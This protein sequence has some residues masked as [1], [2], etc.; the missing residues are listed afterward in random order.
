MP[1]VRSGGPPG[2]STRQQLTCVPELR[3]VNTI[4]LGQWLN[5][6]RAAEH[7]QWSAHPSSCAAIPSFAPFGSAVHRSFGALVA[8]VGRSLVWK[9]QEGIPHP[10]NPGKKF[11][12]GPLPS[13]GRGFGAGAAVDSAATQVDPPS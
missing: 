13:R 3:Q 9:M 1:L 7:G 8:K 11:Q 12:V 4:G 10:T 5:A 2:G 6:E